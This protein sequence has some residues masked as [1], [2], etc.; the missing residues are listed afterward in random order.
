MHR[1]E[2]RPTSAGGR[3]APVGHSLVVPVQAA[4]LADLNDLA[5]LGRL[6]SPGLRADHLQGQV[7]TPAVVVG[8]VIFE[9]PPQM[10]LTEHQEVV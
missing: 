7:T 9:D 2:R 1:S 6:H 5:D 8:E 4:G 3:R 10:P